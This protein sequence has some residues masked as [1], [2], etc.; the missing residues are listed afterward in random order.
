MLLYNCT[1]AGSERVRVDA[2]EGA[3]FS[4][5]QNSATNKCCHSNSRSNHCS[6]NELHSPCQIIESLY[7]GLLV[8]FPLPE[9]WK[10]NLLG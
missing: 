1:M 8:I 10:L 5:N 4:G 2:H 9:T 6:I 7:V 3:S